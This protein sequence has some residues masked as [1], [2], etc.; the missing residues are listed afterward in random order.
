VLEGSGV[1]FPQGPRFQVVLP[2][3]RTVV[4]VEVKRSTGS[5]RVTATMTAGATVL[6]RENASIRF[7]TLTTVLP[8]AVLAV[9][10]LAVLVLAF[11][12]RRLRRKRKNTP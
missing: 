11:S 4:P 8:W 2:A 9:V 12:W 6:D 10:V 1:S 7:V 3:G 5:A